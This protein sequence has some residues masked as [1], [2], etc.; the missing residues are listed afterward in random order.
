MFSLV[1]NSLG[2]CEIWVEP[3]CCCLA[4]SASCPKRCPLDMISFGSTGLQ[5]IKLHHRKP[6]CMIQCSTGDMAA[7]RPTGIRRCYAPGIDLSPMVIAVSHG[8]RGRCTTMYIC[9]YVC[10]H[11]CMYVCMYVCMYLCMNVCMYVCMH[12]CMYARNIHKQMCVYIY[13]YIYVCVCVCACAWL[14]A[15]VR[16]ICICMYVYML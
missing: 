5:Y 12:V 15:C 10:M 3:S 8:V 11:A 13:I 14:Y 2:T 1:Q 4:A 7:F 9:M 6:R 16:H